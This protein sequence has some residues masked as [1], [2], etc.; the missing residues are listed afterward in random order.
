MNLPQKFGSD[1]G[2]PILLE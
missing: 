2:Q 1:Y